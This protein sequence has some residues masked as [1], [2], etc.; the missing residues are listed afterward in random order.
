MRCRG[1]HGATG[2]KR[3]GREGWTTLEYAAYS[4]E[5]QVIRGGWQE[6]LQLQEVGRIRVATWRCAEMKVWRR[7]APGG[8]N[9]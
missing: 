1:E 5:S 8:S 6:L 9:I 4:G 7:Y 2:P 3:G